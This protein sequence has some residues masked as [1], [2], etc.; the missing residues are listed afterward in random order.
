M[1][2]FLA[3]SFIIFAGVSK[4]ENELSDSKNFKAS[5][6]EKSSDS[7]K[8]HDWSFLAE[9]NQYFIPDGKDFLL[10]AYTANKDW[11]HIE[12]RYNYEAIESGSAWIGYNFNAGKELELN[13]T[14]MLGVVIGSTMGIA[15]GL[16]LELTYGI[17]DIYTEWEYVFDFENS[18]DNFLYTWSEI[19]IAP[20]DWISLGFVAQRTRVYQSELELQRGVFAA[21]TFAQFSFVTYVFNPDIDKPGIVLNAS[22]E[23]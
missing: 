18:S 15:P 16:E 5:S 21:F 17:L 8:L 6:S 14:P 19:S 12:A 22:V 23:F 4:A 11:L 3:A 2:A 7:I 9:I 1:L 20:A 10:P 13:A